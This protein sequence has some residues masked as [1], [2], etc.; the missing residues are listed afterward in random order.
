MLK[1]ERRPGPVHK[2]PTDLR[3]ALDSEATT[4]A[5]WNH[6]TS[7]AQSECICW[8]GATRSRRI[9]RAVDELKQ[10]KRRLLLARLSATS[11]FAKRGLT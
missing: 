1:N 6:L 2:S 4:Q 5:A 9:Q 11:R 10:G 3:K 8:V 7:L